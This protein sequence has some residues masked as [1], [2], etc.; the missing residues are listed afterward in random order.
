MPTNEML[1]YR[2]LGDKLYELS[3]QDPGFSPVIKADIVR[4]RL[5]PSQPVHLE[6]VLVVPPHHHSVLFKLLGHGD[7]ARHARVSLSLLLAEDVDEL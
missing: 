2:M 7:R 5:Q 6:R 3:R 4:R 1:S